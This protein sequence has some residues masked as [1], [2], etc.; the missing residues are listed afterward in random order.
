MVEKN[1]EKI[2]ITTT[3]I[4]VVGIAVASVAPLQFHF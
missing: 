1:M 2:V 4:T 3:I